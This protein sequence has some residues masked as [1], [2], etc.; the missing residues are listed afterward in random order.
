MRILI[1]LLLLFSCKYYVKEKDPIKIKTFPGHCQV[2]AKLHWNRPTGVDSFRVYG[3]CADCPSHMQE[4][5]TCDLGMK[6]I[7]ETPDLS[8]EYKTSRYICT[9]YKFM[10]K[11]VT[12]GAESDSSNQVRCV[13]SLLDPHL[14]PPHAPTVEG[15]SYSW[16]EHDGMEY[17]TDEC[18]N[19]GFEWDSSTNAEWYEFGVVNYTDEAHPVEFNLGRV[20]APTTEIYVDL[21]IIPGF[22]YARVKACRIYNDAEQCSDWAVSNDEEYGVVCIDGD[23]SARSWWF[24]IKLAPPILELE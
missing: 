4:N 9:T 8:F 19:R 18:A 6:L 22:Y 16:S 7:G 23:C 24:F 2:S 14:Q 21:P 3:G 13:T 12:G 17:R 15:N 20:D 5:G 1:V 11:S 10:V